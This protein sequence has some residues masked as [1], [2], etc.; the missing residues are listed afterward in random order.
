MGSSSVSCAKADVPDERAKIV[1]A[2]FTYS[3]RPFDISEYSSDPVKVT[4]SQLKASSDCPQFKIAPIVV[5]T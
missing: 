4:L 5:T 2:Q 1:D 3:Y